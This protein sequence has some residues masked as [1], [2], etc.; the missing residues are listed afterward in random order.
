MEQNS[1]YISIVILSVLLGILMTASFSMANSIGMDEKIEQLNDN[2]KWIEPANMVNF[3]ESK[4]KLFSSISN[5]FVMES[6]FQ[7]NHMDTRIVLTEIDSITELADEPLNC[8]I[9]KN[10]KTAGLMICNI[11][12]TNDGDSFFKFKSMKSRKTFQIF[13]EVPYF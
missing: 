3:S 8:R 6:G 1:R 11:N 5:S 9:D 12:G 13:P 10:S 2:D 4:G 7:R